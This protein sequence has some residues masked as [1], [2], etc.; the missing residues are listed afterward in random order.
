MMDCAR[1]QDELVELLGT[2]QADP[3]GTRRE[4][5]LAHASGCADCADGR[6]LLE[7]LALPLDQRDVE[8]P[9]RLYWE[10]FDQ[11]LRQR[12]ASR[13]P[14]R[15]AKPSPR[16]WLVAAAVVGLALIAGW[17][18]GRGAGGDVAHPDPLAATRADQA[19][20]LEELEQIEELFDP[21]VALDLT[22][23]ETDAEG[24]SRDGWLL[25][26]TAGLDDD[27]RRELLRWL[28]DRQAAMQGDRA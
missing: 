1:F 21:S 20:A 14:V 13:A 17:W 22:G 25:P 28:R 10:G 15:S 19:A 24:E 11:R 8:D 9:G 27:G 3:D 26:S 2:S 6:D 18:L 12:I 7:W 5:L 4:R 16:R 23:D